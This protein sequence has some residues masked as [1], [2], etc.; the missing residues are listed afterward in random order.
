MPILWLWSCRFQNTS[1]G[2]TGDRSVTDSFLLAYISKALGKLRESIVA[3]GGL[4][5]A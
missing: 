3:A 5:P 1:N 4:R 2:I